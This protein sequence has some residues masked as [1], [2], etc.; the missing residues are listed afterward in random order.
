VSGLLVVWAAASI[1][2]GS[3]LV[4]APWTSAV[5][6]CHLLADGFT[7][8]QIFITL[9][10]VCIGFC[11]GFATGLIV[12]LAS[13]S[14]PDV[15]AFFRPIVQFFQGMP[16][17]LWAIPLVALMGIGHLPAITVISLITFPLVAVTIG[18][19]MTT[20]PR[21]YGEMLSVFAPGFRPRMLE[22]I[23]PHL[24]PF[25]A[26]SVKAGL[27][28]A[29]KASVT[30][31]YFGANNGIGFQIQSAYMALRIRS[32]F[33]WAIILILVILT[34]PYI[35]RLV[36]RFWLLASMLAAD[37]RGQTA[38]LGPQGPGGEPLSE[39]SSLAPRIQLQRLDFS[40]RNGGALLHDV[41]LEVEPGHVA[42]ICGD[43]GIGKTTLL[44]LMAGLLTPE[45]GSVSCPARIGFVF[46]DDRLLPWRS[47]VDNTALPLRYGGHRREEARDEAR[48]LLAEIG[49]AEA[50]E[51]RPGELSG[52]MKKRAS[53]ARCFARAPD[54]ILM[55]EP[56]SGLHV[57]ARKSLWALFLRLLSRHPI[58]TV[59]VTHY[60]RELEGTE[61]CTVYRLTGKPAR[62]A[63][64]SDTRRRGARL[65]KE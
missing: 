25:L 2:A 57:E 19:G 11:I 27:V 61:G 21:S 56:F 36:G 59:V 51:K 24:R 8:V 64:A 4:P 12:G 46:Q 60:P 7:W 37:G 15:N 26:A 45:S 3:Y 14:R 5:D 62:L 38:R 18:E 43:S 23:L 33:A 1:A 47:V 58:P 54:A 28:L 13:G 41:S 40:W 20:L 65:R 44:L 9:A 55:D 50:E 39:S 6:T 34:F 17:L 52:G 29:V 53:L 49:L 30:A 48:A 10:R 63:R 22:L 35:L 16:P 42:V 31:E 32:L